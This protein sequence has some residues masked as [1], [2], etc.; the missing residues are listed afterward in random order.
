MFENGGRWKRSFAEE[1]IASF[2]K[3]L[4][5]SEPLVRFFRWQ[6]ASRLDRTDNGERFAL[7][8]PD[9]S[10]LSTY[11]H[12]VDTCHAETWLEDADP[13][14]QRRLAPFVRTGGDGSVAALWLDGQGRQRIVHMGSGSGSTMLCVLTED[15]VDFLRLLAIGYDELCWPENFSDTPADVHARQFDEP[16]DPPYRPRSLLRAWVEREFG[17]NVPE[18]A[19]DIV[20][21]TADMDETESDDPF[22][23]WMRLMQGS[24]SRND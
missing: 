9:Q 8:D 14:Q 21:R 18:T 11:V 12:P 24:T 22:W 10:D 17:V 15:P 5:P 2:P 16:S 13:Q 20:S 3:E 4:S 23:N 6:E 1:M 19:A 7:I